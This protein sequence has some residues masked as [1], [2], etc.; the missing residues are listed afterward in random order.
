M[1]GKARCYPRAV[2]VRLLLLFTVVPIVELVLLVEIG[3]Y[4]GLLP[5]LAIVMLTGALGASLARW[6]GLATLQRVQRE[7]AEG[8]VPAGALMDGLLILLAGALLITPGLLTDATGFLLLIPPV[9]AALQRVVTRAI[10]RRMQ[11]QGTPGGV[12]LDT[13]WSADDDPGSDPR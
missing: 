8:R 4:V 13:S 12:V 10:R 9:R 3:R 2:F 1:R 5:T 7:M 11:A 6:Q